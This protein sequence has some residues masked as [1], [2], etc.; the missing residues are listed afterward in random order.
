MCPSVGPHSATGHRF[1][2]GIGRL[3]GKGMSRQ[4]DTS[5]LCQEPPE[6]L[7]ECCIVPRPCR[8]TP[9]KGRIQ[10]LIGFAVAPAGYMH[11]AASS[12]GATRG[13]TLDSCDSVASLRLARLRDASVAPRILA[14]GLAP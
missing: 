10:L 3:C 4:R 11:C 12:R 1:L 2:N 5:M 7:S 13:S 6:L 8:G 14:S 9:A